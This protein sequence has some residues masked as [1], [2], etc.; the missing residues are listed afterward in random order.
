MTLPRGPDDVRP[1]PD[2]LPTAA[3]PRGSGW[4]RLGAGLVLLGALVAVARALPPLTCGAVQGLAHHDLAIPIALVLQATAVLIAVPRFMVIASAGL[5]FGALPGMAVV[6]LGAWS[7]ACACFLAARTIARAPIERWLSRQRW[8]ARV[9]RA[10]A[11]DRRAGSLFVWLRVN[12]IL[13]FTGVS[14]AAGLA[15]IRFWPYAWG[16]A[17]GMVPMTLVVGWAGDV[18]GCALLDGQTIDD[19]VKLGLLGA[20]V[21]MTVASLA[22]VGWAWWKKRGATT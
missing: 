2:H 12:P 16:T 22:P 17:V 21:L 6:H 10:L 11:D 9:A 14:Y 20:M 13:H 15:P 5:T 8:Y 18:V 7:G 19:S 1:A 4:V 3:E